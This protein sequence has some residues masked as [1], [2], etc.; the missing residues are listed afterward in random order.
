[1]KIISDIFTAGGSE[2]ELGL[3]ECLEAIFVTIR[4]KYAEA[5]KFRNIEPFKSG[6]APFN[7]KGLNVNARILE[8][9]AGYYTDISRKIIYSIKDDIYSM[10]INK[11]SDF[12]SAVCGAL[13]SYGMDFRKEQLDN[14]KNYFR[15]APQLVKDIIAQYVKD[16]MVKNC[17][18]HALL[19]FRAVY[20]EMMLTD[21][22]TLQIHMTQLTA[23]LCPAEKNVNIELHELEHYYNQLTHYSFKSEDTAPAVAYIRKIID[24]F[25]PFKYRVIPD[26]YVEPPEPVIKPQVRMIK[27]DAHPIVNNYITQNLKNGNHITFGTNMS[28]HNTS[29]G[30]GPIMENSGSGTFN[31]VTGEQNQ[32]T[33]SGLQQNKREE[34]INAM[35]GDGVIARVEKNEKFVTVLIIA[36]LAIVVYF[37]SEQ[38]PAFIGM[39]TNS[40]LK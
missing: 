23:M 25:G 1:M 30:S 16:G 15:F 6:R 9:E 22:Y 27:M 39:F 33:G 7:N 5:R 38:M 21:L 8:H 10:D 29:N 14:V 20:T 19:D 35:N 11:S 36:L 18:I 40:K 13:D 2:M 17:I 3:Y 12:G 26:D 34:T 4:A 24:D 32:N 28:S 37:N 31:N